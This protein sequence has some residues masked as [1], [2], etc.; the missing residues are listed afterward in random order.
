MTDDAPA[1]LIDWHG[2]DWAP[3][4]DAKAAH[5]NA[6]FTAPAGQCPVIAAEWEDPKGVPIDAI[7]FGG[8]RASVV[9]LVTQALSWEHGTC[10]GSIMASEKTAAAAGKV[11]V[12][13]RD[14][15]AMLPFCGY[16]M[17][18]YWAHWL[19]MGAKG[20]DKMPKVFYVN[21][22]RKSDDGKFLWPGYGENSRVLKWI[23]ER[24]AGEGQ[25]VETPIGHLPTAEALDTAGL[26]LPAEHLAELLRVDVAGWLEEIPSIREHFAQFGDKLPAR[27][28][29]ELDALD[30]RLRAAK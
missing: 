3:G 18:D 5:P 22:F 16:H 9:P 7:L 23:V 15:M 24:C 20:G 2:H 17:A 19:A 12:L 11:G 25:A 29:E 14:P 13:R 8:R 10:L 27:L 26:D 21:W 4:G 30:Q 1:H 6:R 28:R